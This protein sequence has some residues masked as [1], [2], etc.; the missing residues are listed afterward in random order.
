MDVPF[1]R[2]RAGRPLVL[3]PEPVSA[4]KSEWRDIYIAAIDMG[5]RMTGSRERAFDVVH[6]TYVDMCTKHG[7]NPSYPLRQHFLHLVYVACKQARERKRRSKPESEQQA[8]TELY[9]DAD[10]H[11]GSTRSPEEIMI[12]REEREEHKEWLAEKREQLRRLMKAVSYNP[13][14]VA[15]MRYWADN[16]GGKPL[17]EVGP[18]L[19]FTIEEIYAAKKLIERKAHR[20]IVEKKGDDQ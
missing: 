20:I 4:S 11:N 3:A 8:L 18:Q 14:A 13:A 2:K 16:G 12:A 1:V 9:A 5:E 15:L 6:D 19:G 7:H 17:T 10:A